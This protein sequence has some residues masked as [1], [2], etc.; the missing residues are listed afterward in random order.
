M[1]NVLLVDD[2]PYIRQG[3]R[4]LVNW[5]E[6]GYRIVGEAANGIEALE[7]IRKEEVDL[8]F[9]DMKM[10]E[11][12]GL[13]LIHQVQETMVKPVRFVILTGFADFEYA[14]TAIKYHVTEYMLK[15]VEKQ[16]LV[17]VLQKMN[18]DFVQL[19]EQ[20][21]KEESHR[22]LSYRVQVSRVLNGKYSEDDRK[23]VEACLYDRGGDYR[24][25]SFEL[26]QHDKI[27]VQL[28]QEEKMKVQIHAME[29]LEDILQEDY[30]HAAEIP[31]Q[32]YECY[33][34][35]LIC[36]RN[37]TESK[38]MSLEEYCTRIQ[39][40]LCSEIGIEMIVYMGTEVDE[41]SN[42]MDSYRS[43]RI[44]RCLRNFSEE[45]QPIAAYHEM[46]S[47][48][49]MSGL[50][51]S[52]ID[53]LVEYISENQKE[54]ITEAVNEFYVRLRTNAGALDMIQA[55]IYYLWYR[56]IELATKLDNELNQEEILQYISRDSFERVAL[57]GSAGELTSFVLEYADYLQQIKST[58]TKD[59]LVKIEQYAQE[60]YNENLSLKLL[61]EKFYINNVYLGQLFKKKFEISFREYMN[62]LRIDKAAQLLCDSNLR[63]YAIAEEVGF[64]NADYFI[65][66]FVQIMGT[67]PQQYRMKHGGKE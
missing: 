4:I 44:T 14:Q 52:L 54:K 33:G 29:C 64:H 53:H 35:G 16:E 67:T 15:P 48:K 6:N 46:C 58:E 60:H 61:G 28:S 42:L 50:E 38:K 32:D 30:R 37:F 39:R 40:R 66:K 26:D 7:F 57:G 21:E 1:I 41:L 43:V 65:N 34:V 45:S 3:L 5:E 63:V 23:A 47:Q 36:S 51:K 2:E 9:V 12:S 59:V 56:L 19:K 62:Q 18:K 13:E 55:N 11:M 25:I 31:E 27:F 22:R 49:K 24:Y 17:R 10:P 20:K 8:V